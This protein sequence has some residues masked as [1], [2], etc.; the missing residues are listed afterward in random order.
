M[1][2]SSASCSDGSDRDR[3]SAASLSRLAS[4][5]SSSTESTA[6]DSAA[7]FPGGTSSAE[8]SPV[9]SGMPPTREATSGRPARSVSCT[10]SGCPSQT[11]GSTTTSAAASK[12]GTSSRLPRK[13]ARDAAGLGAAGQP[14]LQRPCSRDHQQR[15]RVAV[16]PAGRGLE[17][18]AES[19]LRRQPGHGEDNRGGRVAGQAELGPQPIGHLRGSASR[20]GRGG[21]QRPGHAAGAEPAHPRL[22]VSRYAEHRVCPARD[23]PLEHPVDGGGR[24]R[25]QGVRCAR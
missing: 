21:H 25:G 19:L 18:G 1:A 6:A 13:R 12:A 4:A 17:Q 3:C 20:P 22:E 16:P 2:A 14:G 5:G 8:S 7:G 10:I 9:R 24:D 23:E 11:L 15:R